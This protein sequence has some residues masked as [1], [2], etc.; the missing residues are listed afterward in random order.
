ML[1]R[2]VP[3]TPLGWCVLFFLA[4]FLIFVLANEN[5]TRLLFSG[6][7]QQVSHDAIACF[8]AR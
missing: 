5:L 2:L 8:P 7:E 3:A 6:R 4:F 1:G